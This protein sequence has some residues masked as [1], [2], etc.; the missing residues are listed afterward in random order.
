MP[1]A[2]LEASTRAYR[3]NEGAANLGHLFQRED[4]LEK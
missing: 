3:E 1:S 2:K 4:P